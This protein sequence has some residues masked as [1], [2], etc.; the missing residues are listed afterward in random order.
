MPEAQ[1]AARSSNRLLAAL[2][3][4]VY[5]R[6]QPALEPVTLPLAQPLYQLGDPI[7]HVYFPEQ[8]IISLV[9]LLA[10]GATMEVGIVGQDGMAGL[11]VLFGGRNDSHYAL[12]QVAGKAQRLRAGKLLTEFHRG[13][14]LHDLLLRYVQAVL[15]QAAQAAV[16]NRFHTIEARLARWLLSASDCLATDTFPLTHEFISQMIGVRRAGVTTAA[17]VLNQAGLIRYSRGR[18]TIL[19]RVSLEAFACEC[20]GVVREAL[21]AVVSGH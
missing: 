21:A 19:D 13:E 16:C 14:A 20:Y 17:G 10:A 3:I 1:A 18:I 15:T 5:Q 4:E 2:P 11:P 9:S 12:V 6:L 8:G 7:S